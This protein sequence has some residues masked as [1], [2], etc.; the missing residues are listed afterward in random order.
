M[1]KSVL[2]FFVLLLT[3]AGC[4]WQAPV[5]DTLGLLTAMK[6][7]YEGKWYTDLVFEQ[8]T[9]VYASDSL[10]ESR[11]WLEAMQAPDRLIV[12]YDSF[13]SGA[14]MLFRNDSMYE[15]S[16]FAVEHSRKAIHDLLLMSFGVYHFD[17]AQTLEKLKE[18]RF[19]T[20]NFHVDNYGGKDVYVIG[21]LAGDTLSSQIW[22]EKERMVLLWLSKQSA[23]G[24]R[25]VEFLDYIEMPGGG[26]VPSEIRFITNGKTS[27]VEK[28]TKIRVQALDPRIFEPGDFSKAVWQD[29]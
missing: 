5:E 21:A 25:K 10:V 1:K 15:F 4:K 9:E 16:H 26:Y 28:Y 13:G 20:D 12:L 17:P 11:L 8:Q 27:I 29:D 22:I 19:K 6:S 7:R 3:I 14:G 18:N 24:S 2:L 23:A